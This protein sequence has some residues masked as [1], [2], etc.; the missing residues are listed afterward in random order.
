[1][2]CS[3]TYEC[4]RILLVSHMKVIVF[5]N[6]T[7]LTNYRTY[8]DLDSSPPTFMVP[9]NSSLSLSVCYKLGPQLHHNCLDRKFLGHPC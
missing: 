1:M 2:T 4:H 8:L 5:S 3:D 9:E 6:P 7:K